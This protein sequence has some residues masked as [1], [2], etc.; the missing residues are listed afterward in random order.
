M[1]I[2][3]RPL[4]KQ[5]ITALNALPCNQ[6]LEDEQ[7]LE[8]TVRYLYSQ[9]TDQLLFS[10]LVKES[11]TAQPSLT[12]PCHWQTV[13]KAPEMMLGLLTVFHI[14]PIPLH[15]HPGSSGAQLV[16]SGRINI[17]QF[18]QNSDIEKNNT[19]VTLISVADRDLGRDECAA[20]T[21]TTHNI[22]D[23]SA[24]TARCVLLSLQINPF[25]ESMRS[26]YFP[27]NIFN[28]D[29]IAHYRRLRKDGSYCHQ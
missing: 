20:Y 10:H 6:G 8:Q 13:A 7:L 19:I 11:A 9:L 4:F 5:A 17:R 18:E 2:Q 16:L 27:L 25:D 23:M 14:A 21:P 24:I 1:E 22:H 26:L 28:Q 29:R 12:S 15:D 3:N